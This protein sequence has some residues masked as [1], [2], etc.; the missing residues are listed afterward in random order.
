M[1]FY[2]FVEVAQQVLCVKNGEADPDRLVMINFVYRGKEVARLFLLSCC[3]RESLDL[4][5]I[6]H[7]EDRRRVTQSP[8]RLDG[9][10][11]G[12]E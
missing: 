11:R 12:S 7:G 4:Y 9:K 3:S 8:K 5:F 1:F 2:L 6:Y 10:R